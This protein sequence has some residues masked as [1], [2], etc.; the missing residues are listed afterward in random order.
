M[1]FQNRSK[2]PTTMKHCIITFLAVMALT[3]LGC[4]GGSNIGDSKTR[5]VLTISTAGVPSMPMA[6][7]DVE[8]F[9]PFGV[10]PTLNPDASVANTVVQVSGVAAPG[11]VVTPIYTLGRNGGSGGLRFKVTTSQTTGFGTGK[12]AT[13]FLNISPSATVNA[14]DFGFPTLG[15]SPTSITGTPVT[16]LTPAV[17][18]TL[19]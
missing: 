8:V 9:F 19:E 16:G 2:G 7:V 10:T 13:V 14:N 12:F 4:G 11:T 3:L 1:K 17:S 5:A 15:F 18:V 6:S